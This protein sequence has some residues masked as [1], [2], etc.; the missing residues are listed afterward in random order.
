M[1]DLSLFI[2]LAIL[3]EDS[4]KISLIY[5]MN[6]VVQLAKHEKDNTVPMAFHPHV[7]NAA[8]FA[9]ESVKKPIKRC[10]DVFS[11]RHIYPEH[12]I[13]EMKSALGI[14]NLMLRFLF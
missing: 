11:E 13:S 8:T 2:R 7:V 12:V 6:D 9:S 1:F 5:V 3:G 4:L 10:L 14:H